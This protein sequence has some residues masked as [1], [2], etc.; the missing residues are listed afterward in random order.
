[1]GWF[2]RD[3]YNSYGGYGGSSGS[4]GEPSFSWIKFFILFIPFTIL[5]WAMA[6]SIK[7]KVMFTFA[8][9]IGISIALAGKSM[10]KRK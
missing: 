9:A 7:W 5:M 2:S 10:R 8:G 4:Y 3:N 6:P 1:M